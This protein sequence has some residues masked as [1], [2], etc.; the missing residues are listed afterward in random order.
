[1][2]AFISRG[3]KT[4][5]SCHIRSPPGIVVNRIGVQKNNQCRYDL[6]SHSLSAPRIC[7]RF[8]HSNSADAVKP[9]HTYAIFSVVLNC[10]YDAINVIEINTASDVDVRLK[11][12]PVNQ[13]REEWKSGECLIGYASRLNLSQ[14]KGCCLFY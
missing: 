2:A 1:M 7:G 10:I 5:G 4:G 8:L 14:F 11:S 12:M 6:L 9:M 13:T 3:E